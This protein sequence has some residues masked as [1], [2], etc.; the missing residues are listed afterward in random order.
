MDWIKVTNQ[1]PE[2]G[3]AVLVVVEGMY[4]IR[5]REGRLTKAD[6]GSI[7]RWWRGFDWASPRVTYWQPMPELPKEV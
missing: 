2:V 3:A 4:G 5:V 6:P 7:E 1:L